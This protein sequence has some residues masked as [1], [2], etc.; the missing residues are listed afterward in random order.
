MTVSAEIKEKIAKASWIRRMYETGLVLKKNFGEENVFDLSLG[1]PIADPPQMVLDELK[2]LVQDPQPGQHR[3]MPNAGFQKTR[4]AVAAK[5]KSEIN[6]DFGYKDI[7][8]TSGTSCSISISLKSMVGLGDEV[9]ILAPYFGPYLHGVNNARGTPIIVP[10]TSQFKL[11]LQVIEKAITAKT[12]CLILNSPN[13]PTGVV[14]SSEALKGLSDLLREKQKEYAR[15]ITVLSDEVYAHIVYDEKKC[16]RMANFYENTVI[17]NSFSKD[18]CLAGERI[19][20]VAVHP[21]YPDKEE[22]IK[23]FV[24]CMTYLGFVN[25]PALMQRLITRLQDLYLDISDY[26]NKRDK[27][28][29]GLTKAGYQMDKPEGSFFMFVK[30][31]IPDELEFIYALQEQNVL[32]VPGRAFGV[33]GYIRLAYCVEDWV[34]DGAIKGFEKVSMEGGKDRSI[35]NS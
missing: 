34:I 32:A 33:P 22:L 30:S 35:V 4:E 12:C 5:L 6:L 27:L 23:A 3:Y 15:V 10:M 1:N 24:Y 9:I 31:P 11:D 29:E 28:F 8:M 18:L 14:Y 26:Q 17:L 25:A 21:N 16:P 7:V 19:G 2:R 20:Y 13:N